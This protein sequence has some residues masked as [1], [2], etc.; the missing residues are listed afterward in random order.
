MEE[1]QKHTDQTSTRKNFPQIIYCSYA[2]GG[3]GK[4][5]KGFSK[6]FDNFPTYNT[7]HECVSGQL[8]RDWRFENSPRETGT[9]DKNN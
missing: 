2:R 9:Y 5:S 3:T 8:G 6:V 4:P 1:E 7:L